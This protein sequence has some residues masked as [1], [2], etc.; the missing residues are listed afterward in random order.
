MNHGSVIRHSDWATV[1]DRQ[2]GIAQKTSWL[3]LAKDPTR[4]RPDPGTEVV[5]L[6]RLVYTAMGAARGLVTATPG[7]SARDRHLLLQDNRRVDRLRAAIV[8]YLTAREAAGDFAVDTFLQTPELKCKRTQATPKARMRLLDPESG[9]FGRD[10]DRMTKA[11]FAAALPFLQANPVG[12][13]SAGNSVASLEA[14]S[15]TYTPF[16][17]SSPDGSTSAQPWFEGA[18]ALVLGDTFL[19][20]LRRN[21]PQSALTDGDVPSWEARPGL[22]RAAITGP[23]SYHTRMTT[24]IKAVTD[25][26]GMVAMYDVARGDGY[27]DPIND[28]TTL[29]R[30]I[31]RK[32]VTDSISLSSAIHLLLPDSGVTSAVTDPLK[33][34]TGV[35]PLVLYRPVRDKQATLWES[36][37]AVRLD[38]PTDMLKHGTPPEGFCAAILD[39][40]GRGVGAVEKFT[41]ELCQSCGVNKTTA[42]AVARRSGSRARPAMEHIL[43]EAL[44][45]LVTLTSFGDADTAVE[46]VSASV[47]EAVDIECRL[48]ARPFGLRAHTSTGGQTPFERGASAAEKELS[49]LPTEALRKPDHSY[50]RF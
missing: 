39:A 43:A 15:A 27:A 23:I 8:G 20:V 34:T 7:L 1:I 37:E 16:R 40:T 30:R 9:K 19:D 11:E 31:D 47:R 4:Y 14:K 46:A 42:K 5:E 35:V 48:Q 50:A 22:E 25:D 13:V 12:R 32:P 17:E 33:L 2:S 26:C 41:E 38:I 24:R 49:A 21:I 36:V 18:S 3:D 45:T 28:I 6:A 44:G 10:V 29:F